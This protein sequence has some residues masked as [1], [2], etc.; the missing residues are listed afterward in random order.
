MHRLVF[1][2]LL[3]WSRSLLGQEQVNE[4]VVHWANL[5]AFNL[6]LEYQ[7]LAVSA[8]SGSMKNRRSYPLIHSLHISIPRAFFCRLEDKNDRLHN[9]STRFRLGTVSY[10]DYLEGKNNALMMN[11]WPK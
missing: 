6:D 4:R 7:S 5:H 10:T 11:T 1:L 2:V 3:L 9:V 8:F